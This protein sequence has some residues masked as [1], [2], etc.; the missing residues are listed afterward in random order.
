MTA[1]EMLENY[2]LADVPCQGCGKTITIAIPFTGCP[3]CSDCIVPQTWSGNT[4]DF[5]YNES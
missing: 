2:K 1:S 3:F 5:G 4:E